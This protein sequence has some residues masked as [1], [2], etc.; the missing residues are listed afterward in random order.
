MRFNAL[1]DFLLLN[2]TKKANSKVGSLGVSIQTKIRKMF[3]S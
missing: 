1:N 2:S 3:P